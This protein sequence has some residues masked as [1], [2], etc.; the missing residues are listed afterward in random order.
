MTQNKK[1]EQLTARPDCCCE[2]KE[3]DLC[4]IRQS[5]KPN[6]CVRAIGLAR[7]PKLL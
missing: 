2:Q 1:T 6:L 4:F 3:A 5:I 7:I